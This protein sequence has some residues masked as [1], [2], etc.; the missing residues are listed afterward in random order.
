MT[1]QDA[2]AGTSLCADLFPSFPQARHKLLSYWCCP[3]QRIACKANVWRCI[4]SQKETQLGHQKREKY[5]TEH[6]WHEASWQNKQLIFI[7]SGKTICCCCSNSTR[8]LQW[9][10][11]NLPQ[12]QMPLPTLKWPEREGAVMLMVCDSLISRKQATVKNWKAR[13]FHHVA[14]GWLSTFYLWYS[15]KQNISE[16]HCAISGNTCCLQ[17]QWT[18]KVPFCSLCFIYIG[19]VY[20]SHLPQKQYI[21]WV[22]Q[23]TFIQV[24]VQPHWGFVPAGSTLTTLHLQQIIDTNAFLNLLKKIM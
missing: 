16:T 5:G 8:S 12:K 24:H 6:P 14:E 15:P 22:C 4:K 11:T 7:T 17:T 13:A 10:D 20:M 21:C 18:T 1:R 23:P 3:H 19:C 2:G 9:N